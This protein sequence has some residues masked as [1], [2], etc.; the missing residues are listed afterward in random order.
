[1]AKRDIKRERICEAMI[2]LVL[3]RGFEQTSVE[4]VCER[5]G[6]DRREYENRFAGKDD[7]AAKIFDESSEEHWC[8]VRAAYESDGAW[9]DNLRAAAYASARWFDRHPREIRF[10][11]VEMTRAGNVHQA[12]V[13]RSVGNAI[14]MIDAGRQEL[15][16]PESISRSTAEWVAGS[17]MEMILKRLGRKG[18]LATELVPQLMYTA[19]RP[20]LGEELALEE[21]GIPPPDDPKDRD[22]VPGPS[23]GGS[24]DSNSREASR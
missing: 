4:M 17:I 9:R 16:D 7:C 3:A 18:P 11:T 20:Y 22:V 2:D 23:D 6:V 13:E 8:Q 14:A 12:K 10:G 21:L 19:V 24:P 15:D 5:A 1:M